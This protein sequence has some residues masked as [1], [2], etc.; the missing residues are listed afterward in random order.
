MSETLKLS[1][2]WPGMEG[3]GSAEY[4]CSHGKS[5]GVLQIDL[6]TD[7]KDFSGIGDFRMSDGVREMVVRECKV[8]NVVGDFSTSNANITVYLHDRRHRWAYGSIT[9]EYNIPTPR[10]AD[11]PKLPDPNQQPGNQP[12][13]ATIDPATAPQIQEWSRKNARDLAKLC[14]EAMGEKRYGYDVNQVPKDQYPYV[15][16][17]AE[18]PADAL[19]ALG[20]LYGLRLV[21][22][23]VTNRAGLFKLGEGSQLPEITPSDVEKVQIGF[24]PPEPPDVITVYGAIARFQL[25]FRLRAVGL[26]FD[27]RVRPIDQLSYRPRIVD[28]LSW[29][30]Y[31]GPFNF[32][33]ADGS[34]F[35]NPLPGTRTYIDAREL[36]NQTVFRWYQIYTSLP[37]IREGE[38]WVPWKIQKC[39][40]YDV[41]LSSLTVDTAV[42]DLG[43]RNQQPAKIIGS[44]L[45][46]SGVYQGTL[47]NGNT[48]PGGEVKIPFTIDPVRGL[49][50]FQG[51]VRTRKPI[52]N[53]ATF[54]FAAADLILE[55]VAT[56]RDAVTHQPIRF[57]KTFPV[58]IKG[59]PPKIPG[60]GVLNELALVREDIQLYRKINYRSTTDHREN[61]IEHNESEC[62][63]RAEYYYK[64]ELAKFETLKPET[65]VFNG[66]YPFSLDGAIQQITWTISLG[67]VQTI[68][69]R[70]NEHSAYLAK[71]Q[72]RRKREEASLE[73]ST[74]FADQGAR[75]QR[76]VAGLENGNKNQQVS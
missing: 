46:P 34:E 69:S 62:E 15:N 75:V 32:V 57:N 36:A 3:L 2:A 11:I 44:E 17:V 66:V 41:M 52:N 68:I 37:L 54:Q 4:T 12:P 26:D 24:D 7:I 42:D 8:V 16:W 45:T 31:G 23:P 64:G 50:M 49:V 65:R 19:Q 28:G 30:R 38:L 10:I 72:E 76:A 60:A 67:D 58:L 59:K 1:G 29:E 71:Y 13:P 9:G 51:F 61:T 48:P 43:Q 70:N 74:R 63:K 35:E 56:V 25:R 55:T 6:Q 39:Q 21:Y 14:F 33:K 22:N 18:N 27:G 20:E 47:K 53:G 40:L 5:P 73:K